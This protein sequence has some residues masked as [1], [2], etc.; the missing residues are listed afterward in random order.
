MLS[1]LRNELKAIG[2]L[3]LSISYKESNTTTTATI[4]ESFLLSYVNGK[5]TNYTTCIM[6]VC[7]LKGQLPVPI[8]QSGLCWMI[9]ISRPI[10][11]YLLPGQFRKVANTIRVYA[12]NLK[13][14]WEFLRD[15]HLDWKEVSLEQMSD[16]IH[17]LKVRPRGYPSTHRCLSGQKRR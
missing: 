15:K 5:H 7:K 9:T 14:F 10:Q 17:W 3:V 13:L 6:M 16:F 2:I 12:N 11:K 8:V 1:L 4:Y